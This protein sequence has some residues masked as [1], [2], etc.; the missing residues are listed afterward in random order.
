MLICFHD[1]AFDFPAMKM[2]VI[3]NDTSLEGLRNP[4]YLLILR[5]S[6]SRVAR[7][8]SNSKPYH[9]IQIFQ[10]TLII[11]KNNNYVL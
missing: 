9:G 6:T 7:E 2:E 11:C 3:K 5:T 10:I 8:I 1:N 4:S